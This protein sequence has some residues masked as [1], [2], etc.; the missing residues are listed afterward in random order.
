MTQRKTVE[1]HSYSFEREL[2][3]STLIH[4]KTKRVAFWFEQFY[5]PEQSSSIDTS[6]HSSDWLSVAI[7]QHLWLFETARCANTLPHQGKRCPPLTWGSSPKAMRASS[8]EAQQQNPGPAQ[9]F[10]QHSRCVTTNPCQK[11]SSRQDK[12]RQDKK[13]K[14]IHFISETPMGVHEILQTITCLHA[15]E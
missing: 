3:L 5:R 10:R 15:R 1:F 2:E 12:T 4:R 6:S 9:A 14:T 11:H 8:P 13:D 7:A